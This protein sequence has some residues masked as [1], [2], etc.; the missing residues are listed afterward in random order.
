MGAQPGWFKRGLVLLL[1]LLQLQPACA[2]LLD[3]LNAV[4]GGQLRQVASQQLAVMLGVDFGDPIQERAL[5]VEAQQ[6]ALWAS[7]VFQAPMDAEI[8]RDASSTSDV[9]DPKN[10][11]TSSPP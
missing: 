11:L 8:D 9:Y 4:V 3:G 1:V 10:T 2:G 6:R 5:D 7:G